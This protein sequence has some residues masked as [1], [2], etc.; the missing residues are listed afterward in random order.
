[1]LYIRYYMLYIILYAVNVM[2]YYVEVVEVWYIMSWG[3]YGN[4][5]DSPAACGI[6]WVPSHLGATRSGWDGLPQE[7]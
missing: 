2:L 6:V 5:L 7:G 3:M 1:M 4:L